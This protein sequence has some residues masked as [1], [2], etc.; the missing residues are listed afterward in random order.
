MPAKSI[1][2]M[3]KAC[4]PQEWRRLRC[5]D[6]VVGLDML[7]AG[8]W[9]KN[10]PP[11]PMAEAKPCSDEYQYTYDSDSNVLTKV[12][13][14]ADQAENYSLDQT[15]TYNNLNELV[16]ACNGTSNVQ[17]Y[18]LDALGNIDSLTNGTNS[19]T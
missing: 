8:S 5:G 11:A 16:S 13:V 7:L 3:R 2:F 15:Y 19:R 6:N 12:N 17:S 14:V 18:T 4:G 9:I 1:R 10:G